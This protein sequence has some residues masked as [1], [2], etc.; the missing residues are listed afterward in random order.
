MLAVTGARPAAS[1]AGNVTSVPPPAMALTPPATSPPPATSSQLAGSKLTGPPY[2]GRTILLSGDV[3]EVGS[4]TT[5]STT[6]P[7]ART[8]AGA[9]GAAATGHPLA[10]R[11][12]LDLLAAGGS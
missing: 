9:R 12:A 7:R 8:A 5:T 11:A 2:R 3:A 10:T 4:M 6:S 1:S